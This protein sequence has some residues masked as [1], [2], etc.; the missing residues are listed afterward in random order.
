VLLSIGNTFLKARSVRHT[1][2]KSFVVWKSS[3]G[4]FPRRTIHRANSFR[5]QVPRWLMPRR[6]CKPRANQA[7]QQGHDSFGNPNNHKSKSQ[8]ASS[9]ERSFPSE[10]PECGNQIFSRASPMPQPELLLG[11]ILNEA[12]FQA[13]G[14]ACP[15]QAKRAEGISRT[16]GLSRKQTAPRPPPLPVCWLCRR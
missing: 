4:I 12:V 8:T 15:E 9:S 3:A 11:V 14:R 7:F 13:E 10:K 1:S 2:T 16:P 6:R 5:C